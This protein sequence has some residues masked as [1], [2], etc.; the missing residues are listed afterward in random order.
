M[1]KFLT[2][3]LGMTL[4]PWIL[5]S[6][7]IWSGGKAEAVPAPALYDRVCRTLDNR[8]SLAAVTDSDGL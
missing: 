7:A 4:L 8:L 3:A 2:S 5:V 6:I 1:R